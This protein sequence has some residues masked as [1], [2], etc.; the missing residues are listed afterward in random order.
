MIRQFIQ[1]IYNCFYPKQ[2]Q[3]VIPDITFRKSSEQKGGFT[4]TVG[5]N[6]RRPSDIYSPRTSQQRIYN[7]SFFEMILERKLQELKDKI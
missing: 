3:T 5:S 7:Y 4:G 2:P 6:K 1:A